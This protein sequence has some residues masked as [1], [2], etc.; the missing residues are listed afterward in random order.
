MYSNEDKPRN[1]SY[2]LFI[3]MNCRLASESARQQ[4]NLDGA[5]FYL[6]GAKEAVTDLDDDGEKSLVA[7]Q[8]YRV[9][10][11]A[12]RL[13]EAQKE[14]EQAKQLITR[15]KTVSFTRIWA[16]NQNEGHKVLAA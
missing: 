9:M 6:D 3:S 5:T 15:L 8:A 14:F 12:G 13:E 7:M 11:D 16:D 4:G 1:A 2:C 10:K